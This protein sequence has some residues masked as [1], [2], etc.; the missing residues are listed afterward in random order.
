MKKIFFILTMIVWSCSEKVD[1]DQE[2]ITIEIDLDQSKQGKLSDHFA[3]PEY[4]I[5]DYPDSNPVIN[6]YNVVFRDGLIFIRDNRSH[7]LFVFDEEGHVVNTI[8]ANGMGPGEYIQMDDFH[9][10]EDRIYIQDTHLQKQLIFDS[11][12]EFIK[13]IKNS[14]Q[15]TNFYVADTYSIYF[16]SYKTDFK[17]Y[18]FVRRDNS[19]GKEEFFYKIDKPLENIVRVDNLNG[20]KEIESKDLLYFSMPHATKVVFIDKFSGFLKDTYFFDFGKHNVADEKRGFEKREELKV[21]VRDRKLVSGIDLIHS[22]LDKYVLFVRQG[23]D[24]RHYIFMDH[25][26]NILNQWKNLEND[27]DGMS[28]VFPW[29]GTDD[30]LVFRF[31]SSNFFNKYVELYGNKKVKIM[32]GNIHSFFQTNK[33]RLK[34][35]TWVLVKL[36]IK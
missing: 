11:N 30:H 4:I 2:L 25:E 7:N 28:Y 32:E 19:T 33:K 8:N 17:G 34:E 10:T 14:Y 16:M 20:L 1:S 13:E 9:V 35:D 24:Q 6:L 26:F 21:L 27:I 5:L 23:L 3:K 18:N 31:H 36:K 12:G 22:Y 29:T 15:N